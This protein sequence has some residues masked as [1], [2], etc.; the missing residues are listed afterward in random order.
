MTSRAAVLAEFTTAWT[1]SLSTLSCASTT[2]SFTSC[3]A[4][5]LSATHAKVLRRLWT[6]RSSVVVTSATPSA[7]T[8]SMCWM[9]IDK[10]ELERTQ[11]AANRTA[12]LQYQIGETH[13]LLREELT[14]KGRRDPKEA[15][16]WWRCSALAANSEQYNDATPFRTVARALLA[17]QT[18]SA[19]A[20]RLFSQAGNAEANKRHNLAPQNLEMILVIR[21]WI[22]SRLSSDELEAQF[23]P[24]RATLLSDT[25]S[26]FVKICEYVSDKVWEKLN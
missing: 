16:E 17:M 8:P 10:S 15:L 4:C 13:R 14:A 21:K 25:S 9:R 11:F 26:Q 20:E 3:T 12:I 22:W 5:Q 7:A 24:S 1:F 23:D 18:S 6:Q 19:A 2:T